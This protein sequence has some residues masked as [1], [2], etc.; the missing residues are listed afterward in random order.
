MSARTFSLIF[1]F[2]GDQ[3][4]INNENFEKNIWN[5]YPP[6]PQKKKIKF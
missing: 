1:R 6:E 3:I 4:A 5:I 2:I